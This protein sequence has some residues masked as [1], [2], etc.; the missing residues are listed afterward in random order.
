MRGGERYVEVAPREI[1]VTTHFT[2]V[3]VH[4]LVPASVSRCWIG[5]RH[6]KRKTNSHELATSRIGGRRGEEG[7]T[8]EQNLSERKKN[9]F[10]SLRLPKLEEGGRKSDHFVVVRRGR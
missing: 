2:S 9:Y 7:L 3:P 8:V 10:L 1:A 4:S 6:I 5:P